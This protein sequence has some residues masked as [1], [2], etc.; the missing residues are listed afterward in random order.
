M[1][2]TCFLHIG[3]HKTASTS[4]QQSL[5]ANQQQLLANGIKYPIFKG[6]SPGLKTI[7]NHSIPIYS[8]FCEDPYSYHINMRLLGSKTAIDLANK[9]YIEQLKEE[10]KES[11]NIFLSGEDVSMLTVNAMRQFLDFVMGYGYTIKSF[12]FVREPYA[13][14]CSVIQ[15]LIQGGHFVPLL[16]SPAYLSTTNKSSSHEAFKAAL[17]SPKL[18]RHCKMQGLNFSAYDFE[19]ARTNH[20]SLLGF[21]ADK[22]DISALSKFTTPWTNSS[23][24]NA[25]TRAKNIINHA[26]PSNR[27]LPQ[28]QHKGLSNLHSFPGMPEKFLLTE[29][30][31]SLMENSVI[32]EAESILSLTGINYMGCSH[33]FSRPLLADDWQLITHFLL[34][35]F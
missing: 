12:A 23:Q 13:Y 28:T 2:K 5:A 14:A 30:E 29:Y 33:R 35:Q 18:S 26:F 24:S 8:A 11:S 32:S 21:L 9:G 16:Q 20:A 10:L 1:T 7:K 15:Q 34:K 27:S 17:I 3:Y 22:L 25:W 19:C 4:I 31:Y 6:S